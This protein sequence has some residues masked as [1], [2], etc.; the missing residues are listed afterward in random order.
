MP[1]VPDLIVCLLTAAAIA[2]LLADWLLE[3]RRHRDAARFARL[4]RE[5]MADPYW[6]EAHA[7]EWED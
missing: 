7:H 1:E 5:E 2:Y 6:E 4:L 3:R